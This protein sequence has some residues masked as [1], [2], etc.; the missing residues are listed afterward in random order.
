MEKLSPAKLI[1]GISGLITSVFLIIYFTSIHS[2]LVDYTIKNLSVDHQINNVTELKLAT[3]LGF[4]IFLIVL[5]SISIIFDLP[6]KIILLLKST[7]SFKEINYFFINDLLAEKNTHNLYAAIL[8]PILGL[9]AY[10]YYMFSG[11]AEN[12]GIME[13]IT[14]YLFPISI[15]I[16]ITAVF[17]IRKLSI[18]KQSR[19]NITIFILLIITVVTLY[20]GEEISWGQQIF[21]WKAEGVFVKYNYQNET[22]LHNFF[23]PLFRYLYPI[24]GMT[25]FMTLFFLWQFPLKKFSYTFSFFVPHRSLFFLSFLF[26]CSSFLD[27]REISEE[28]FSLF[29]L[30]YSI[31]I[32]M[33]VNFP[34][35]IETNKNKV[36]PRDNA[37]YNEDQ[38]INIRKISSK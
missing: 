16:L 21:H 28:I 17:K 12:E 33:C 15:I 35:M 8:G 20:Y 5:T 24:A 9:L 26:A 36:I 18:H 37:I 29:C 1:F 10:F 7:I 38:I 14:T 27:Y 25:Q 23:N 13:Y 32:F 11:I 31:R 3:S 30:F 34:V 4:L 2:F 19:N 6:R 22:N